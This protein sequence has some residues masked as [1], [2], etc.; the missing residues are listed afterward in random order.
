MGYAEDLAQWR[1][2][3]RQAEQVDRLQQ[4]QQEHAQA[5]R[6]RDQAINNNEMEEAAYQDN[7]C[8]DLEKEYSQ[9]AGPPQPQIDP[10]TVEYLRRH[11]PFIQRHGMQTAMQAFSAAH[12]HAVRA[13]HVPN[14]QGYFKFMD[15]FG[16]L[17]AKGAGLR[18]DSSEKLLGRNEAAKI[19]GL[20][21]KTYDAA[22]AQ[23]KK[24]GRVS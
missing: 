13:G 19:S 23:L 20:D 18:F 15:D 5:A 6:E 17:Y 12:E 4:I 7:V 8:E 21:Q 10:R 16:D 14:T 1:A 9:I 3:R 22:Y 24:Q 2:Q 11:T